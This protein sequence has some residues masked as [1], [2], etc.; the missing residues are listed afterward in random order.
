[1]ADH[2]DLDDFQFIDFT[3]ADFTIL[4]PGRRPDP[5]IAGMETGDHLS[6][7][8]LVGVGFHTDASA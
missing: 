7:H 3:I 1:M 8:L 5:P 2:G 6:M 4:R